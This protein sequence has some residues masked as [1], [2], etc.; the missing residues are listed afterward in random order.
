M[1]QFYL[2][3]SSCQFVTFCFKFL[4]FFLAVS[5]ILFGFFISL[6]SYFFF[7]SFQLHYFVRHYCGFFAVFGQ[8]SVVAT[9]IL[10]T[11][12]L[13]F[14]RALYM[15]VFGY[16]LNVLDTF[17][18]LSHFIFMLPLFCDFIKF[19]TIARML[20]MKTLHEF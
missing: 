12:F 9:I 5:N 14:L 13:L 20:L 3:I 15:F 8:N 11:S 19:E 18:S 17:S 4:Y 10:F 2:G 16:I 7:F 6:V 1:S